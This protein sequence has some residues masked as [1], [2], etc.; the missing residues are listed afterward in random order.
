M[1]SKSLL[2]EILE[3]SPDV[4]ETIDVE[5]EDWEDLI[6][7]HEAGTKDALSESKDNSDELHMATKIADKIN[8]IFKS[9]DGLDLYIDPKIDTIQMDGDSD[10]W[11]SIKYTFPNHSILAA[12]TLKKLGSSVDSLSLSLS[13]N[14][15]TLELQVLI[16]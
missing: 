1:K 13:G 12:S 4:A 15:I 6:D 2:E 5:A 8:R 11:A 3:L 14:K 10:V 7:T 9:D 16:V